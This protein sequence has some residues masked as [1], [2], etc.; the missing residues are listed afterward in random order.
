M[1]GDWPSSS[2]NGQERPWGLT[3]DNK[4]NGPPRSPSSSGPCTA[5]TAGKTADADFHLPR[6]RVHPLCR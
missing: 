6:S 5:L 1:S 3:D 4:Y 2:S